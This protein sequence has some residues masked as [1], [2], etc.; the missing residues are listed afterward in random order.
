M[1]DVHGPLTWEALTIKA[2]E[3]N[4][5]LFQVP[6]NYQKRN[7]DTSDMFKGRSQ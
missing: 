7:V 4:A 1:R 5:S 3:P 2:I 6:P